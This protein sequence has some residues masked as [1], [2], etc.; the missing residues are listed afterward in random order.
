MSVVNAKAGEV[1]QKIADERADL[2]LGF[3][4]P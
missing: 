4:T 3:D 2:G 1:R